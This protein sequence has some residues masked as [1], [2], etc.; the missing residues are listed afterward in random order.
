MVI[1]Q[2][3]YLPW[4]GYFDMMD[5]CDLFVHHV[6]VQYDKQSWRNRN[7]IR[8][9]AGWS[10]LSVP[11]ELTGY[12]T[13]LIMDI[14][15]DNTKAWARKHL[16]L[17]TQNYRRAPYFDRYAGLFESA[18]LSGWELLS[19]LDLHM[20]GLLMR[21]LG[22][23]TRTMLSTEFDLEG[24]KAEDRVLEIC[25]QAGATEYLNGPAGKILYTPERFEAAGIALTWHDY[26]HP[27]Y[28]QQYPGFVPY[29]SVVD[30]LFNH[31]PD[32]MDII[33]G[34]LN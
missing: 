15:I 21:E 32:S 24:L 28:M 5:K 16:N 12:S 8:T 7:R 29:L 22:L 9:E 3:G 4:T 14:R 33:R 27:E 10:W 31:G 2:P 25:R 19:D 13:G 1:L 6:D 18:L 26:R 17:L 30:L 20:A 11:V 34:R 23:N